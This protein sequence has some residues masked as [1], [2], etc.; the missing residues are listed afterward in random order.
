MS[1]L[2]I[3]RSAL[4]GLTANP[5]RSTLTTLGI[6]IGV[7]A[8]IVLVAVGNGS[9]KA[10]E[11]SIEQ[12]GTNTLTVSSQGGRGFSARGGAQQQQLSSGGI[13]LSVARQ[14][15]NT[16]LAPDVKS[17]TPEATT[18]ATVTAGD[19]SVTVPSIVGTSVTYF[20]ATN[21]PISRGAYFTS[22]DVD[23]GRRVAVIG[24]TT[25]DNLFPGVNAVGQQINVGNLRLTVVGVLADKGSTGFQDAGDTVVA[26]I[27][28]VQRELTGYGALS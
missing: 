26:P 23:A 25:A 28:T 24:S 15:T 1:P 9:S 3:V 2:E 13:T 4:R 21:S 22:D 27:S 10:I 17:V 16:A 18:S 6:L 11:A 5:L 19:T 20:E 8:V 12:L 14:L 7:G